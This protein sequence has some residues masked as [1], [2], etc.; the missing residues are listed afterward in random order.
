VIPAPVPPA[1]SLPVLPPTMR[2]LQR[3]WLSSNMVLFDDGGQAAL[4]DS[5]YVKHRELTVAMVRRLLGARPLDLLVNTH[6]HSDHC[7]GNGLLQATWG[8]RTLVPAASAQAV[9]DWDMDRLTYEATGQRCDRFGFDGTIDDGNTLCLGGLDWSVI[10]APG[11]DPDGV[12]LH[13]PTEGIL[14]SADALWQDGFGVIF[15]ELLGEPGFD[16]QRAILERIGALDVRLVI[17][18][19]GAMFADVAQA[20][21]RAHRRLDYLSAEP[22]RNARHAIKV[23]LK[24]LLLERESIPLADVREWTG[25]TPLVVE[26]NR[27]HLGMAPDELTDW[28]VTALVKAGAARIDGGLLVD[29]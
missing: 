8:C 4:V 20:L 27:R 21:D 5:G 3:D 2:F 7:G 26:T 28:A 23:L 19:H 1:A 17:P 9:R 22:P 10:A 18:G 29:A 13:C 16:A 15:P 12:V 11:H 24:F 14:I 6:L 25:S